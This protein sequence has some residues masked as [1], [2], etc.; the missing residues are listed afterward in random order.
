M[1][2]AY[3]ILTMDCVREVAGWAMSQQRDVVWQVKVKQIELDLLVNRYLPLCAKRVA[4]GTPPGAGMLARDGAKKISQYFTRAALFP[5][6]PPV[7]YDAMQVA[8]GAAAAHHGTI[9]GG[10]KKSPFG[11]DREQIF[12]DRISSPEMTAKMQRLQSKP[13]SNYHFITLATMLLLIHLH[14]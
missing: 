9:S 14:K 10:T 5:L 13:F 1:D 4:K 6:Y 11:T 8:N 2:V 7:G 12:H 3:S